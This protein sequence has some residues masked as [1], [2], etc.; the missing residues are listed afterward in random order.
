MLLLNSSKLSI[1]ISVRAWIN[2]NAK[3][4]LKI[5]LAIDNDEMPDISNL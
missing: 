5:F 1:E 3:F 2:T 4:L